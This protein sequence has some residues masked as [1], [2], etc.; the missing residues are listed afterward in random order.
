MQQALNQ[1]IA[2]DYAYFTNYNLIAAHNPNTYG[3][4]DTKVNM[5]ILFV[6]HKNE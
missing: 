6:S 5:A 2:N 3:L 1:C 4:M